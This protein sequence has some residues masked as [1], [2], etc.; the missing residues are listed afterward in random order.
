MIPR[1]PPTL[2][3]WLDGLKAHR[4]PAQMPSRRDRIAAAVDAFLAS[5]PLA[6][7]YRLYS[8]GE[9]RAAIGVGMSILGPVLIDL[10]WERA[11]RWQGDR[12]ARQ[13]N[14]FRYWR[15]PRL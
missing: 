10:G 7:R 15:P 12:T 5:Q 2:R 6:T 1:R 11:R 9:L 4:P 8:A 3:E 13:A 14:Y